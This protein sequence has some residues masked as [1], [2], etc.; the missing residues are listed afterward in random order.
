M[1]IAR[2]PQRSNLKKLSA[3]K[4]NSKPTQFFGYGCIIIIPKFHAKVKKNALQTTVDNLPNI[5]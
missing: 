4:I 1:I 2:R 3:P 5:V